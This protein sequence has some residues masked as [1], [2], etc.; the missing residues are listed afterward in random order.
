MRL[1]LVAD[2]MLR[3]GVIN[4][5]RAALYR[6][7]VKSGMY[8]L[9][10]P[11]RPAHPGPFIAWTGAN[12][13]QPPLLAESTRYFCEC[14]DRL[15]AGESRI[16]SDRWVRTQ[17]PP[18]W[19]RSALDP[20]ASAAPR[21]H[22]SSIP[23]FGLAGGDV[24]GYWEAGRF[25]TLLAM[26]LGWVC[27]ANPTLKHSID[28]W[29]R[30]W[31]DENPDN[32]GIQW[33]C[34]QE[35]GIRLMQ[36]LLA[37]ELL[38]KSGGG[39][40]ASPLVSIV[41]GHCQRIARTM[42]YAV[43]QD[44]NHGTS[45][46]AALFAGGL[47]LVRYASDHRV[48]RRGERWAE[49]GRRRLQE[50]ILR[51]VAEDGSF[52]QH[53]TNYHRLM[54]DT[55][56]FAETWR[57]WFGA[58][59]FSEQFLSRCAA[60]TR[61]LA[62]FV[63]PRYGDAANLGGNDGARLF[64]M[65]SGGYRDFRPSV[66]WASVLFIGAAIYGSRSCKEQLS[67]LGFQEQEYRARSRHSVLM[68]D[69][70]YAH[71]DTGSAHAILRL[72]RFVFR[73]AHADALHLDLWVDGLNLIRD[74]GTYSYNSDPESLAYYTGTR[75]H[76]TVEF[77]GRDQ[78]PRISRFLF[79]GWLD[80]DELRFNA[81]ELCVQASYT[82]WQGACH[83]RTVHLV[84]GACIVADRVSGSFHTAVVRW[85]MPWFDW[86]LDGR[87]L[88]SGSYSVTVDVDGVP[89]VARLVTGR[90]SLC[91]SSEGPVAVLEVVV[92]EQAVINTRIEWVS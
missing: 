75:S 67:W 48:A 60:A 78:M 86:V 28:A 53:S 24:K 69:G 59:G 81:D 11:V 33:K 73:P 3:L 15:A 19:H 49:E 25:D 20:N 34:G 30:S 43:A 66:D 32:Q 80:A 76:S 35:A 44:N 65:H 8:R 88:R 46:A 77:D 82:D 57:R 68:R 84:S 14:A 4:V 23:D 37:V 54:L 56:S 26:T 74:A 47:F 63:D 61:W 85:R 45:E 40:H 22:W 6:A 17:I 1:K 70:G 7:L 58:E 42:L 13:R 29:L 38:R 90:E 21:V 64:C 92:H 51:L 5:G 79:G 18:D 12:P 10:L 41:D 2:T 27:S 16:Y 55:C 83:M 50:R 91:Y 31:A 87:T 9:L 72:P 36:L 71:L 62:E 89:F 52:S 39:G